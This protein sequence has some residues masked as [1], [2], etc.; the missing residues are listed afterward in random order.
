MK[1][2]I[3]CLLVVVL[4]L[5]MFAGCSSD[6]KPAGDADANDASDA[7]GDD[8]AE[9]KV[10]VAF[11]ANQKFGD[12][13]PM[14]DMAAGADK[15]SQEFGVEVKKLESSAAS[16]EEDIRAMSKAGYNLIITTFPYMT[17]A[18][19]VVSKE[20]PDV[21]YSA[22]FQFINLGDEKYE[23]IW[24]TEFHGEGGFYIAGYLA[25]SVTKTNHIGMIIGGEEP[26]PNAEG[27]A[28]MRGAKAANPDVVV[29]CAFVGS[30]EDPAKAKEFAN[31]MIAKGVD[32][33]EGD[34]GASNAG[35]VEAAK[36]AGILCGNE[37]T[38]FY[39]NY[40]GFVGI[41]GIGFGDTVYQ[42]IKMAVEGNYP[43]G[44]HGIRDLTNGGYFIDWASYERFAEENAEY[45][46]ALAAAI[47]QAKAFEEQIISG[48]LVIEFDTEVPNWDRIAAE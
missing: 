13:G 2:W 19:K 35:I 16:F 47:E 4:V 5:A 7:A 10:K 44:E 45:G 27:N 29:E 32:F 12:N 3:T 15:A 46:P 38:D 24:D 40:E 9:A 42:S 43:A 37:I 31:A 18:T 6:S 20:F 26:T 34:A 48:E 36:D 23:N 14:D 39:G 41:V 17:D 8:A 11:V 1:K 33:I 25:G 21:N 28:F 30:Y 22:I